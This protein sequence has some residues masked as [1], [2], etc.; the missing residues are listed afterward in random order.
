MTGIYNFLGEWKDLITKL[1][2]EY[3][4]AAALITL[5][6]VIGF[7]FFERSERGTW[8]PPALHM[9]IAFVGW[10][11]LVPIVG[12]LFAVIFKI[13]SILAAAGSFGWGV[14]SFTFGVYQVHPLFVI[15]LAA[16][17]AAVWGIW[18]WRRPSGIS[19]NWQ[20]KAVICC[21]G[22]IVAVG[23]GAPI[24][25]LYSPPPATVSESKHER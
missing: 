5:A 7:V 21:V 2:T 9:I 13:G 18:H 14:L 16:L 15:I 20:T 3:P 11:V 1:Y 10:L 17:A 6:A 8:P 12:F 24:I 4:L 19:F 23:L 25:N 22:F